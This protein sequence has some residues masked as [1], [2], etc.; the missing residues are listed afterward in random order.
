M[1]KVTLAGWAE[2][3]ELFTFVMNGESTVF[4]AHFL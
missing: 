1:L 2:E 3:G 4:A